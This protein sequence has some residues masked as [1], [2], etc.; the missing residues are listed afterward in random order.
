MLASINLVF[1]VFAMM[2]ALVCNVNI[3]FELLW[4]AL[5]FSSGFANLGRAAPN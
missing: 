2:A 1:D 4:A 3:L 5:I